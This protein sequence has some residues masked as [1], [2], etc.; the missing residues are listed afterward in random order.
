MTYGAPQG[1]VLRPLLFLTYIS[2]FPN[3]PKLLPF[4][5]FAD[6]TN[7]HFESDDLPKLVKVVKKELK[8]VKSWLDCNKLA[9]SIDKTIFVLFYPPRKK[10]PDLINL[11][12]GNK[13]IRRTNYVKFLGIFVDEYLSSKYHTNEL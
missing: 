11:K 2:D 4:Y 8:R 1:S 12:I 6:D 10:S 9:L 3:S 5:F 13:S 7:I